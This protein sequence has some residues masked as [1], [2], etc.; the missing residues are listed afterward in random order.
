MPLITDSIGRVLGNRYRLVAALGTGASAHVYLAEDVT[1]QRKVAVKVLQPAFARDEAFLKR[2]RAEARSV[3]SLNHPHVL[4][5]FDWGEDPDGPYLVVEYLGGG[6]LRDL[7][8]REIH[9]S[10]AQAAVLGAEVARGLAYAHA[11]GLVHRDVK[12]ANLLFDDEGRVRVTDFGVARALAEAA[13]TEPAG[14]MVG[15]ARYAS[16]EQAEGR[17]VDGRSDVY[18]LALVLCEALTGTVPFVADTTVG[19]LMA[20]VGRP[21]PPDPRLGPLED[22]LEEAARPDLEGRLDAAALAARLE[23]L[24]GTLPAA[25]PLPLDPEAGPTL[26]VPVAGPPRPDGTMVVPPAQPEE[27]GGGRRRR[28]RVRDAALPAAAAAG[29]LAS[30]DAAGAVAAAAGPGATG[31]AG[32]D[33]AARAPAGP[34]PGEPFDLEAVEAA[35]AEARTAGPATAVALAT[36]PAPAATPAPARSRPDGAAPPVRRRRRRRWPW[37]VAAVVLLAALGGAAAWAVESRVFVASH[38]TPDL[39]GLTPAQAQARLDKVHFSLQQEPAVYSPSVPAGHVVSQHPAPASVHKEGAVVT[40]VPSRGPPPEQ[41]GSLAGQNCAGAQQ[42]LAKFHVTAVCPPSSAE[43]SSTIPSGQVSHWSWNGQTNPGTVPYGAV[44]V[45]ALSKGRAPVTVPQLPASY[46][47][48]QAQAALQAV[49]LGA[50]ETTQYSTSV[51]AGQIIGSTP[52]P[53]AA[54]PYQSTV[55]VVISAGPPTTKVPNVAGD[56]P[57]QANAA[58]QAAGLALEAVYGPPKAKHVITSVPAAGTTVARGTAVALY[59]G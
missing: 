50:T 3:A 5:V 43:Y 39:L 47:Y 44:V 18:S 27:A 49:G 34:G 35:E 57:D 22:L 58:L 54:A 17:P 7:L 33:D 56:T 30:A 48:A 24:S 41:I 40:V 25:E 37:V 51:P 8:D 31:A 46:G 13:W 55:T 45:I 1:L 9:L 20:R 32:T 19:T 23:A 29:A 26:A 6:S 59:T 38:P 53:G 52:A 2:F 14:A 15:T 42:A 28:K 11:R 36:R 4:R 12:P 16:P 21:L 10:P